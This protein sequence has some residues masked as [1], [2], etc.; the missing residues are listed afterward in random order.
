MRPQTAR[1]EMDKMH[2]TIRTAR[3]AG[4]GICCSPLLPC[5]I[6][7]HPQSYGVRRRG[8]DCSKHPS[9]RD[10]VAHRIISTLISTVADIPLALTLYRLLFDGVNRMHAF[11]MVALGTVSVPTTFASVPSLTTAL[12][13]QQ[14]TISRQRSVR[15]SLTYLP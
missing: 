7:A 9:L 1:G 10:T 11:L 12:G 8:C 3:V 5:H 15:A 4:H 13:L 2:P 14:S 6:L